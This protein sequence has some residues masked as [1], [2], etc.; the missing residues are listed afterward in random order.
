MEM[1]CRWAFTN[2]TREMAIGNTF[3]ATVLSSYGGFWISLAITFIPG[4]FNILGALEE[5][6]HGSHAMFY[7]SLALYLFVCYSGLKEGEEEANL[8]YL[9]LVHFHNA[10]HDAHAQIHCGVL[11]ALFCR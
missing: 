9:G 6:D 3:G 1:K 2:E 10:R 7:H 5:A 11:L 4:G 8:F